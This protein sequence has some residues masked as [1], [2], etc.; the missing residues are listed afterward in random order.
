MGNT[1]TKHV[2][3]E[4]D[5][6]DDVQAAAP[7]GDES[8]PRVA[9]VRFGFPKGANKIP[10]F[11]LGL[12]AYRAWIEIVFV[13]SF[14]DF[15][16]KSFAGHDAFD[17]V[18]AFF[19]IF[20]AFTSK[21]IS[22]FYNKRTVYGFAFGSLILSTLCAFTSLFLPEI[23]YLLAWPAVFSGGLGVA[24]IILLWSEL[25]S[26]LNPIRVALYY[27]ASIVGAAL[28]I[29]LACGLLVPWLF[30]FTLILPM[31]SL[32]CVSKGFNS[33]PSNELPSNAVPTFSFPWKLV[34][35]MAIY[36][37]AY[38]LKEV[39]VYS[40][41]LFGPH[42]AFGTCA[43]GLFI[44]LGVTVR[45]GKFDFGL[46]YR[47]A[48][49]LMVGA[50]LVLPSLGFLNQTMSGLF[51]TASYTAFSILIMIIFSNICYRYGVSA[52]W[53]FGIERG[54]RAIAGLLGRRT[55]ELSD[56]YG[57]S[58]GEASLA[59]AAITILLVV[60]LTM[61]LLSEKE[62]SSK[63]GI[64]FLGGGSNAEDT[65][66]IRKQ[67]LAN[68]CSEVVKEYG[69][70]QREEEVLLLLAQGK[71]VGAIERE[72]FIANG[73]AKTHIRHIY[74]KLDIHARS[75]LFDLLGVSNR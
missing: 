15:P 22:P 3:Y 16:I 55:A 56:L 60:A 68:R 30:V 28:I 8:D 40:T 74:R 9:P 19:L 43:V 14:V 45:G 42:A 44:F 47:V 39:G 31:L 32:F 54:V 69:L 11:F 62:L 66:I 24:L 53:L 49:P 48:L 2:E 50:F 27:S 26:C 21:R 46:I 36:A 38:G 33:L 75:E 10:L 4:E 17:L 58:T 52:V 34:L 65:A 72:L 57:L 37:F 61:I 51:L 23:S 18:M 6:V 12:A 63:W 67:E 5:A 71:T 59:I 73:T 25:Y 70:S 29:Y 41:S 1:E 64:S 7:K 35:L 20:F 13:G